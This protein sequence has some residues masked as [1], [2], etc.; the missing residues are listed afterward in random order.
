MISIRDF[1]PE[2]AVHITKLFQ[3]VYEDHYVYS[4]MYVPT[5]IEMH[6]ANGE[7]HSVVAV[8]ENGTIVGHTSLWGITPITGELGLMAVHPSA[9]KGGLASQMCQYLSDIARGMGMKFL[10]SNMVC[11]HPYTQ[12]LCYAMGYKS[13]C[14]LIDYFV[15]PYELNE[16]ES[17]IYGVLP[18]QPTPI[19]KLQPIREQQKWLDLIGQ[20]LGVSEDTP[21]SEFSQDLEISDKVDVVDVKI[22][23]ITDKILHEIADLPKSRSLFVKIRLDGVQPADWEKLYDAGFVDTGLMP[24]DDGVWFWLMQRGTRDR[25]F[26]FSCQ[27]AQELLKVYQAGAIAKAAA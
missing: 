15:S 9:R 7:W 12:R 14:L 24:D 3:E 18:L 22:N 6:N 20:K 21:S 25:D 27:T 16:R 2:D 26:E 13:T 19:P 17:V 4:D 1:R 5:M 10:T 8:D 11:H 23:R